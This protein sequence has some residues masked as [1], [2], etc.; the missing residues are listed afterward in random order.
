M[1]D[2]LAAI[3]FASPA[4]LLS[5]FIAGNAGVRAW[6]EGAAPVTDDFTRVDFAS[7]RSVYSGFGQGFAALAGPELRAWLARLTG[8]GR[9]VQRLREPIAPLL[10]ERDDDL[11]R[12]IAAHQRRFDRRVDLWAARAASP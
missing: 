3:G 1:R 6:T 10:V 8:V 7:A 5:L 12:E 11:L 9:L 4:Q 2:D